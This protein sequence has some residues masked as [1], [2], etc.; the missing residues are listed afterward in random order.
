MFKVQGYRKANR[1]QTLYVAYAGVPECD[2]AN[3][4]VSATQQSFNVSNFLTFSSFH[5]NT[6]EPVEKFYRDGC[7]DRIWLQSTTSS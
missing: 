5:V 6:I 3:Y 1:T 7:R 4:L 2:N